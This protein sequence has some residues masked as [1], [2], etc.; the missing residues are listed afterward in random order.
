MFTDLTLLIGLYVIVRC[1]SF[2]L[3]EGERKE[4]PIVQV[5]AVVA[6]IVAIYVIIHSFSGG[7]DLPN[8]NL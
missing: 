1:L 2:I 8:F 5:V 4:N 3:R 6:I 7:P